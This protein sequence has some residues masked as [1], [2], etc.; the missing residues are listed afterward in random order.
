MA[1]R[2]QCTKVSGEAGTTPTAS[3][4]GGGGAALPADVLF[5]VL[6]RL[7]AKDVCRLRGVCR[8]W[9]ALTSDATFVAAHAARHR[10]PLLVGGVLDFDAFPSVDVLLMDLSGNV[11]KRIRHTATHLVLPTNLDLVCV[12][13][14]YS[15]RATLLNPVTGAATQLPETLSTPHS[16]RGR[17]LRDF[18]GSFKYGRDSNGDYKVLRILTDHHNRQCPDQLFE[19]LTLDESSSYHMRWRA[20]K[21]L[22]MCVR[23]DAIGSVIINGVVYF[24]LDGR[25]NGTKN[26]DLESYE[27]DY[28]ALF[29]LNTEKWIS[30]LEG[31]M[32]THPE[33]NSI[34][35]ILPEPLDMH[36]YQNLSLSELNGALVVAQY[37][38]YRD[39]VIDSFI[40][41]WY[42]MDLEEQIWEKKHRIVLE[43][44]IRDT[45]HIF[46]KTHPSLVLDDGRILVCI[47]VERSNFE[48]QYTR[49]VVRLY[50]PE[51]DTLSSDLV[52]V[53]NIHSIGFFTGSLLS[54]QN[55]EGL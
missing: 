16:L 33:M 4:S 39:T 5:E 3:P 11:V 46:P 12:T 47:S 8:S 18:D 10:G 26:E 6:L 7:G 31:P 37:T 2:S 54:V 53:R 48:G 9:R 49:R 52:D 50:D 42:L 28:M 41:L 43:M 29:D 15:C 34:D 1:A 30:Y 13:E 21:A 35:E 32:A 22:P 24:L 25:P 45:E 51:T 17:S 36:V 19:I 20:K 44:S 23:R 55:G 14:V 40:D 38:D 27:M